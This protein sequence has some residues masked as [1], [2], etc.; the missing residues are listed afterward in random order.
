MYVADFET[1]TDVDDCRVWAWGL[2]DIDNTEHFE[3]GNTLDG[4]MMRMEELSKQNETVY[5]HNLKFDSEFTM[6]WLFNHGWKHIT[7][8]S[9]TEDKTF[10]TL[11]SDKGVFYTMELIFKKFKTRLH[12]ITFRDSLK[13]LPMTADQVAKAYNLPIRKLHIDYAAYREPGHILTEEEVDYLRNDCVI[14]AQALHIQFEQ[15]MTKMTTAS[16]ALADY[17]Q[18][19]G[20]SNFER[21]FPEPDYDSDV[22]QSYKGGF[23]YANPRFTNQEIGEGIVLDVN[24][25]YPSQMYTKPLPYGEPRFYSGKYEPNRL[26]D[27]YIQIITCNFELKPGR[28]PTI[29]LKNSLSFIPTEYLTSSKGED[30]TLCL[31][32]VDLELFFTQYNVFNL[33]YIC[34]WAFKSST[35]LFKDYID[36]WYAVKEQATIEGNSALRSIAKTYLNSLYGRFAVNPVVQNKIPYL[37]DDGSIKYYL[38]EKGTRKPLYIPIGTFITAWA[39]YTTITAAQTVYDRF[40]YADT[41]SLHLIGKEL[42][43]GLEIDDTKLG[44]WKH[45]STFTRAKYIRAKTYIEEINGKLEVTCAGLPEYLHEQVTFDNFTAMAQ[46][47]GKLKPTHTKGGIVLTETV[48]TLRG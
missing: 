34:G 43:S 11:I 20:K 40:L 23:T 46:Y 9:D 30:I 41:D 27:L 15:G 21:W 45:E 47:E 16:N 4:F 5:W 24:S 19:I 25:L 28:I 37:A 39:R 3:Y 26:F 12:H 33:E 44:A 1:T 36:K 7:D 14:I 6:V 29:Q 35:I 32:S 48:F 42:P 10:T 2:C 8:R 22:R 38:G 13:V 31:T 18:I 17:K